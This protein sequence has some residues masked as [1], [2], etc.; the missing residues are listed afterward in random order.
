MSINRWLAL[1][2]LLA[3]AACKPGPTALCSVEGDE[4]TGTPATL[5]ARDFGTPS[6]NA[7]LPTD[8][9]DADA[10]VQR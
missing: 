4:W 10:S 8:D 6:T 5:C 9:E 7:V 3:V 2:G 1:A